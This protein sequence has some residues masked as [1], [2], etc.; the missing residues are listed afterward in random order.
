MAPYVACC[1]ADTI[2][3]HA[4]RRDRVRAPAPGGDPRLPRRR[5]PGRRPPPALARGPDGGAPRVAGPLPRGRLRRPRLAA[6]V[7]RRRQ[8]GRRADHRRPGAGGR[9][10]AGVR[11][12]RRPRRARAVAAALRQRR[13]AAPVHPGDPGRRRD[14]VPGLLR[15]RRRLRPRVAASPSRGPRRP[16]RAQRAEDLG[17]LGAVRALVR[18]ARPH[19]RR[20]AEAPRDL[21]ADRR[22][23]I[24]RRGAAADDADHRPRRVLRA[25]PRRRRRAAG[26]PARRARRRLEDRDAHARPRAR[27][28]RAAAPGQAAHV[29][30]PGGPRRVRAHASTAGG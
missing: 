4:A 12:R 14:L 29:A 10:R 6:R 16:L 21:D 25:V 23:A 17:L 28:G 27:H 1:I 8:A 18:R 9:G 3:V 24:A 26:Q 13:A 20:R 5:A 2:S 22:H 19:A 15:A 11:E 7:R 30:R